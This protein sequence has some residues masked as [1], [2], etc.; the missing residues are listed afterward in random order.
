MK[1]KYTV[2]PWHAGFPWKITEPGRIIGGDLTR[3]ATVS[4]TDERV[5]AN[6]Y[7]IAAAPE[8]LEALEYIRDSGLIPEEGEYFSEILKVIHKAHKGF[9]PDDLR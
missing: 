1:T 3:V 2:G 6:T 7:L 9:Y 4:N 5:E 8:L